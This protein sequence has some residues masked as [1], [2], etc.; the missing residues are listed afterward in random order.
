M[1]GLLASSSANALNLDVVLLSGRK[2]ASLSVQPGWKGSEIKHALRIHLQSDAW[3]AQLALANGNVLRDDQP[4]EEL[5]L[6]N[7]VDCTLTATIADRSTKRCVDIQTW[8]D[9]APVHAD[10]KAAIISGDAEATRRLMQGRQLIEVQRDSYRVG[11][12]FVHS[13]PMLEEWQYFVH[14]AVLAG[15]QAFAAA[16]L[17]AEERKYELTVQLRN[18][19]G[20]ELPD[21][22]TPLHIAIGLGQHAMVEFLLT[23]SKEVDVGLNEQSQNCSHYTKS[24]EELRRAVPVAVAVGQDDPR[25]LQLLLSAGASV[26]GAPGM[27]TIRLVFKFYAYRC[28]DYLLNHASCQDLEL[29]DN[30]IV[31]LLRSGSAESIRK[32]AI[33]AGSGCIG[34]RSIHHACMCTGE[35]VEVLSIMLGAVGGRVLELVNSRYNG[36]TPLIT[37]SYY[38][39]SHDLSEADKLQQ[40]RLLLDSGADPLAT[41]LGCVAAEYASRNGM[42]ALAE[43]LDSAASDSLKVEEAVCR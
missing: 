5:C 37:V 30:D 8:I 19:F 7:G 23:L 24:G 15:N 17:L 36:M 22:G 4:L 25:M 2:L 29:C 42:V 14:L 27:S 16:K 34:P 38:Q 9:A 35:R 11:Q 18:D 33:A 28:L 40:A 3:V 31:I 41:R 10:L 26:T 1:S 39:N 20:R 12:Y 6:A 13:E 43:L 21:G 32:V